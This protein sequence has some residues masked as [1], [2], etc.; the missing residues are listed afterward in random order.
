MSAEQPISAAL[1]DHGEPTRLSGKAVTAE[2]FRVFAASALL[3]RTFTPEEDRPGAARV[4]VLSHAAWQN[5]FGGDP[6]YSCAAAR[7]LDGE[8]LPGHRRSAARAPSI[9]T[10]TKFWKPLVFTPDQ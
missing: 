8:S 7:S 1:T 10:E 6:D 3:G 5:Y 9:V 2:Y 4:I